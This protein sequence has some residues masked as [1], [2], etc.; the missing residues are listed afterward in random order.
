MDSLG[1]LQFQNVVDDLW[2]VAFYRVFNW[3]H[4]NHYK[5]AVFVLFKYETYSSND[6]FCN[7][8]DV[9]GF[10]AEVV[11]SCQQDDV[12][13]VQWHASVL[14]PPQNVFGA[15]TANAKVHKVVNVALK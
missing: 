11:R 5:V 15:V 2:L 7:W 9:F 6:C 8:F 12:V 4:T 1:Q 3:E 10:T 13:R 14:H